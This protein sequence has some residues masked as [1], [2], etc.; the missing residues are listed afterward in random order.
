MAKVGR[1][2]QLDTDVADSLELSEDW[3]FKNNYDCYANNDNR[4]G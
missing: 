3:I 4:K 1:G 2:T